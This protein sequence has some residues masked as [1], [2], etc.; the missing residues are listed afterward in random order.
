MNRYIAKQLSFFGIVLTVLV[1]FVV[2]AQ[3]ATNPE[4]NY[5]GKL[6]DNTGSAVAD[7]TYNMRFWLLSSAS[8]ATTSAE[9]TESLTG[10]DKVQVT[11]GL[12]SVMLGSTT[13]LSSVDFNQTLY[14]GVEIG[15]T[16][17]PTWDGEMSPRKILGSVPSAFEA[18]HA[19]DADTFAGIA[20]TSFLRSDEAD[21]IAASTASTLLTITQNGAG[22]ILN[23][24]DGATEVFTVTDGGL[25][26]IGTTTPS[27]ELTVAGDLRLTGALYDSANSAGLN[28]YVLKSTGTGQ[29]W[30]ATSTLGFLSEAQIDTCSELA[31][32]MSGETGTC[33]SLVLSAD[34]T[35]T[36]AVQAAALTISSTLTLSG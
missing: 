21:A 16:G 25:V 31:A 12:F 26:G 32:I 2:P 24:F 28:G 3:A 19:A 11:N 17:S 34:P 7:G 33:G 27:Q 23:L 9:W 15:G 13:P 18:D 6:T 14:L 10:G 29:A 30:V 4:I 1:A 36:G 5:Q 22:D 8:I 20:T 35:F